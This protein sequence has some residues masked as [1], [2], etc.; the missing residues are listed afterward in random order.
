MWDALTIGH[1]PN[2]KEWNEN[3]I[4]HVFNAKTASQIL[5]TPL[6]PL[7]HMDTTT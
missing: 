4:R 1:L 5:Q 2:T 7:V 3:F 6:L